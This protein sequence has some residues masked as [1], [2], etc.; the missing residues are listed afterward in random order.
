MKTLR[1]Q[2]FSFPHIPSI[3]PFPVDSDIPEIARS[4]L[5]ERFDFSMYIRKWLIWKSLKWNLKEE[6][7]GAFQY[8]ESQSFLLSSFPLTP[9]PMP[10]D[11]L[12]SRP[13]VLTMIDWAWLAYPLSL[14]KKTIIQRKKRRCRSPLRH[15]RRRFVPSWR[16]YDCSK[17]W[18]ISIKWNIKN[19]WLLLVIV[20]IFLDLSVFY[21]FLMFYS[22]QLRVQSESLSAQ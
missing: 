19:Q 12:S 16:S 17:R 14:C 6:M 10:V 9:F 4:V 8:G 13:L 15:N 18:L 1:E 3:P 20:S 22:L 5:V 21:A 2:F 11:S 7:P